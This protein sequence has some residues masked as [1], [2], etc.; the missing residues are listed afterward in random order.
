MN[1][2]NPVHRCVCFTAVQQS[3]KDKNIHEIFFLQALQKHNYALSGEHVQLVQS[4]F[5]LSLIILFIFLSGVWMWCYVINES[6][7]M[8]ILEAQDNIAV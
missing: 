4:F 1:P 3:V 6:I 7:G 2:H 5:F 8:R